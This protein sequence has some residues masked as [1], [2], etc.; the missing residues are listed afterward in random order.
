MNKKVR[1]KPVLNFLRINAIL[2]LLK[3]SISI[4]TNRS[5]F[6][7]NG[8]VSSP[9]G[10]GGNSLIVEKPDK[11]ALYGKNPFAKKKIPNN[12]SIRTMNRIFHFF[13]V[14]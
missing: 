2:N 9:L 3:A 12:W 7:F 11:F 6:D 14:E 5:K 1:P 13:R 10:N 8:A 4:K